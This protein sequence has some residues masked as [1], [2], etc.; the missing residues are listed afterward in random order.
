M[1]VY[2]DDSKFISKLLGSNYFLWRKTQFISLFVCYQAKWKSVC[3]GKEHAD[4]FL[5]SKQ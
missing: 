5:L 3:F 2:V 1:N 4:M